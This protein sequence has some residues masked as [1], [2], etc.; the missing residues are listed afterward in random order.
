MQRAFAIPFFFVAV[1]AVVNDLTV[2]ITFA[3]DQYIAINPSIAFALDR[4]GKYGLRQV[5]IDAMTVANLL[6]F[7]RAWMAA[8]RCGK[9]VARSCSGI[10][11]GMSFRMGNFAM[12]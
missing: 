5:W 6:R 10:V 9:I 12:C 3:F 7:N 2:A 8:G 11:F 4:Y 1:A